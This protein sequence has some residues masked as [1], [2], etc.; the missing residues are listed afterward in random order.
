MYNVMYLNCT[1]M[2]NVILGTLLVNSRQLKKVFSELD[3]PLKKKFLTSGF[4][5]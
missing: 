4:P 3:G 1:Y 5:T 2:Y